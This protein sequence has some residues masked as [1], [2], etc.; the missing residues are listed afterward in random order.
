MKKAIKRRTSISKV[1]LGSEIISEVQVVREFWYNSESCK[2]AY[3]VEME[4]GERISIKGDFHSPLI[5]NLEYEIHGILGEFKGSQQIEVERY[6]T[7]PPESRHSMIA[8]LKSL[9]GINKKATTLYELYGKE[10]LEILKTDP[11]RVIKEAKVLKK[12]AK[13]AQ[14]YLLYEM[15]GE[16]YI[17]QLLTYGVSIKEAKKL[18]QHY[19]EEVLTVI[20]ENPYML[21]RELKGFGFNKCEK[22]ATEM[23][24]NLYS[25]Y[26]IE[27]AILHTLEEAT[28]AGHCFLPG[29]QL[30]KEANDL[31]Q[32]Q[33]A[34]IYPQHIYPSIQ[35][36][37]DRG[38]IVIEKQRVY[39]KSYH[40]MEKYVCEKLIRLTSRL[41]PRSVEEVEE[42][43]ATVLEREPDLN[44]EDKQREA[45]IN[46]NLKRGGVF[47]LNGHAG[48]GKTFTLRLIVEVYQEL[49]RRDQESVDM[50]ELLD[51]CE[52]EEELN[53]LIAAIVEGY[54]EEIEALKEQGKILEAEALEKLYDQVEE[55]EQLLDFLQQILL[56]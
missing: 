36:L 21:S 55:P 28:Q 30:V 33:D 4:S 51:L 46:A 15:D 20:G 8:L 50:D 41:T 22:I 35:A 43:L 19:K 52:D 25:P 45:I 29:N 40:E 38:E 54:A 56:D 53:T 14:D 26:R 49:L 23:K 44:L 48:T 32:R 1:T 42:A 31:L 6:R 18:Y 16:E 5:P 12:W 9:P 2:G 34:R 11:E 10:C 39:L 7:I 13:K 37:L 17:A 47:I 3:L 27:A 24:F